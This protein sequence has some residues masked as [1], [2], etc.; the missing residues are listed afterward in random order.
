MY[1]ERRGR[2]LAVSDWCERAEV[3]SG[4]CRVM[5]SSLKLRQIEHAASGIVLALDNSGDLRCGMVH[6]PDRTS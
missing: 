2:R 6:F 3:D 4:A 5:C 1:G